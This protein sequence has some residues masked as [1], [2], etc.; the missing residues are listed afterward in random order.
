M[1]KEPIE[2][3]LNCAAPQDMQPNWC[4]VSS[5]YT[6]QHVLT[7]NGC[8]CVSSC[9]VVHHCSLKPLLNNSIRRQLWFAAIENII[10]ERRRDNVWGLLY[11]VPPKDPPLIIL[12]SSIPPSILHPP[13]S[14]VKRTTKQIDCSKRNSRFP[15]SYHLIPA[16]NIPHIVMFWL[17][18]LLGPGEKILFIP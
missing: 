3:K 2:I 1:L 10:R 11:R 17:I 6:T 14:N 18:P 7:A 15:D 16:M 5:Y 9:M 8:S 4:L 12:L 13:D